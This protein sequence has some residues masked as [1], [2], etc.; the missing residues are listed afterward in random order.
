MSTPTQPPTEEGGTKPPNIPP[1]PAPLPPFQ[2]PRALMTRSTRGLTP[3]ERMNKVLARVFEWDSD[4]GIMKSIDELQIPSL[5]RLRSLTDQDIDTMT[6]Q[7]TVGTDTTTN[8]VVFMEKKNLKLFLKYIRYVCSQKTEPRMTDANW[9]GIT[10]EDFEVYV[11]TFPE[12]DVHKGSATQTSSKDTSTATITSGSVDSFQASIKM[13]MGAFPHF[14]GSIDKWLHWKRKLRSALSVHGGLDRVI[15][16]EE[17]DSALNTKIENLKEGSE[18]K[19]LFDKQNNYMYSILSAKCTK[20]TP[21]LILRKH[22]GT[23]DGRQVF[24][25]MKEFYESKHNLTSIVH[26]CYSRITS[27]VLTKDYPGGA[28][29]FLNDFQ[30]TYL[31]LEYASQSDKDVLEKKARLLGA[32]KDSSFHTVRD[33]LS[34]DP[35]KTY[36][37]CIAILSQHAV[38]Y[39]APNVQNSKPGRDTRHVNAESTRRTG[40]RGRRG[41]RKPPRGNRN[42]N[43]KGRGRSPEEWAKLSQE[44]RNEIIAHR[45]HSKRQANTSISSDEHDN[46]EEEKKK[47]PSIRSIMKSQTRKVNITVTVRNIKATATSPVDQAIVD[48]GADTNVLGKEWAI[49]SIDV[50]RKV[51]IIGAQ[52]DVMRSE[53]H[54]VGIGAT[55]VTT[56]TGKNIILISPES[57]CLKKGKTLLSTNQIRRAGHAVNDVPIKYD[58]LQN[59]VLA[60]GITIPL[61]YRDALCTLK[62]TKPTD[63]EL[64]SLD[65]YELVEDTPWDPLLES[66]SEDEKIMREYTGEGPRNVRTITAGKT[67]KQDYTPVQIDRLRNCLL[68][69]PEDVVRKTLE[70]TTQYAQN[71]VH[72][73]LRQ[74]W[75]ARFPG[76]NCR[77]IREIMSTDTFFSSEPG[78][79]GETCA[80]LYV[81]KHSTFTIVKCMT[82][83]S[84]M[85]DTLRDVIREYGAPIA[86]FSDNARSETSKAVKDILR[87]YNIKDMQC[88]PH[89]PNQNPA[90]QRIGVIKRTTNHV[91]SRTNCPS[92][93]WFNCVRYVTMVLNHV[94]IKRL[95]WKT[96]VEVAFGVTP[97]ISALLQFRWY[98]PVRYLAMSNN[99]WVEEKGRFVGVATNIG[100]A[101]TYY[102]LT[103][104]NQILARSVVA[105]AHLPIDDTKHETQSD[106]P[107]FNGGE[108]ATINP[109]EVHHYEV[110]VE[111]D[112]SLDDGP[113]PLVQPDDDDDESID[114]DT[115][116]FITE[117][118]DVPKKIRFVT[119]PLLTSADNALDPSKVRYPTIDPDKILG[120]K[121]IRKQKDGDYKAKVV[122]V[123]E[124]SNEF[125]LSLGDGERE[126]IIGYN[127]MLE[128]YIAGEEDVEDDYDGKTSWMYD[129]ILDHR[130]RKG[131]YEVEVAWGDGTQSWEPLSVI[132]KDDPVTVATYAR[133]N[134][135]LET[136][137]WKRLKHHV[138]QFKKRFIRLARTVKAYRS[139]RKENKVKFGITV[140]KNVKQALYYDAINKNDL[141][142]EA[143]KKEMGQLIEYN[144][145]KD[146]GPRDTVK[147]PKGYKVIRGNTVFDVKHDLRHKARY[148]AMGNLTEPPK[149]S[150]YSSVVSVRS[151]RIIM[152]LA[153]LNGLDLYA[154]DIGNAYLEANTKE[155]LAIV[156]GPEFRDFNME[157]HMLIIERALYGLRTSGARFWEHLSDYLRELGWTPSKADPDV[158][159]KDEGDYYAYIGRYVDDLI[160][161]HKE[162]QSVI[163]DLEKRYILKGVGFPKYHL[164]GDFERRETP[165]EV[166]TWGSKTYIERC[167]DRYEAMYGKKPRAN[168]FAPLEP[169][170]SPE[171]DTSELCDEKQIKEYQSLMGMLQWTVTLG[172]IDVMCA[173]MTM[174]RFRGAPRVGH[175][176]RVKRIFGY[177][178]NF[179]KTAIKFRTDVP[180]YSDFKTDYVK[181]DWT[182]AYGNCK[183]E[184]P[185]DAPIPKGKKVRI[186]VFAD[187]NLMHD[188]VTGRS[189][190]GLLTLL[191]KTPIDWYS[192]RQATV[193]SATYGSEF[194]AAR[195]A[196]EQ[197]MDLRYTLRMF[198]CEMDGPAYLFGDNLSVITNSTIPSSTLK[199]RHNAI[200]YHRVREAIAAGIVIFLKIK[201]TENP[202]DILTKH[203]SSTEWFPL[204][205]PLIF[206]DASK[207]PED[208]KSRGVL[209]SN[210]EKRK[211][212]TLKKKSAKVQTVSVRVCNLTSVFCPHVGERDGATL[213]SH[214]DAPPGP[215][216]R[217]TGVL[218]DRLATSDDV[219]N[220][221]DVEAD[222]EVNDDVES[223]VSSWKKLMST[224]VHRIVVLACH[225]S[226]FWKKNMKNNL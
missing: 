56:D 88:E 15:I 8:N 180:D 67:R 134:N 21:L 183:E 218:R 209:K 12:M 79:N 109:D 23:R 17:T 71:Y 156:G 149:E 220:P 110:E 69:K 157:D 216:G 166:L 159:M 213:A 184:I 171:L 81:G 168:L 51:T 210:T 107:L 193:E 89:H 212:T 101:L 186:T 116:P 59:L 140:P 198:G 3:K 188:K 77:R 47:E 187:A 152:F 19:R 114:D 24:K 128:E 148:V 97:D 211:N 132:A 82:T 174:S 36:D 207:D 5:N 161:A 122:K 143:I 68:F 1:P 70:N 10:K 191:N 103:S 57:V 94:A 170:D 14:N 163:K 2:T 92:N 49:L 126:E 111:D 226:M 78:R 146:I 150:V 40:N 203:R 41:N 85:P 118:T 217:Q 135:L 104:N 139:A 182:Y 173:V 6:Y 98:E 13:D 33:I 91:M 37:Q 176:K 179:R 61:E 130:K 95:E 113:P 102:V 65:R 96:P 185:T 100:D 117:D 120:Y 7:E 43:D 4:T 164:G 16:D 38:L 93:L 52:E 22:E 154:C 181:Q 31:D 195:I 80:Q 58:G 201:G 177:L 66:D 108:K 225:I 90:E 28:E 73:P 124:D 147:L 138:R 214:Y 221:D 167:L 141:W 83:E 196:A 137:G 144:V 169:K 194:V 46:E 54:C 39:T 30:N 200:A 178:R 158:W 202:A 153:E 53:G 125:L 105:P 115:P 87:M 205:K 75:K 50:L 64:R 129:D 142:R 119:P 35:T 11:E 222:A 127:D 189:C 160:I 86:L 204:M 151:L 208:G 63:A 106:T 197:I 27:L 224:L 55:K 26:K 48:G 25:D 44:E 45:K 136:P 84:Q 34:T 20:H 72:T 60:E 32:I 192:K 112:D 172:R 215:G 9:M 199:K 155:K 62:I 131:K 121:F 123:L 175:L 18:D 145:F 223:C 74:H 219:G 76:L 206:W 190:T 29:A 99:K 162:P 42:Q 165:E 133:D